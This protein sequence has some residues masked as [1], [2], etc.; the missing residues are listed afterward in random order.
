MKIEHTALYVGPNV[1]AN[2]PVIQLTVDLGPLEAWPTGRLGPA[3]QQGL[4]AALPGLRDHRCS[5]GVPGGFVRRLTEDEGT[6]LG[7]VLEHTCIELQYGAG[8]NVH[9]GRARQVEGRPG[10]Y[11]VVYEYFDAEVGDAAG[12]LAVRLLQS[13]LPPECRPPEAEPSFD[14]AEAH[15]EFVELAR[16][17]T[18]GPSTAALVRAAERRKIPWERLDG[19]HLIQF[20]YGARQHRIHAA[21][22]DHTSSIGVEIAHDKALT[23]RLLDEAGIPVPA[24]ARV[25]DAE[26]AVAVAEQFGYPVVVKPLD[27]NQGRGVRPDVRSA[28]EV[29]EAFAEARAEGSGV[30]V[31]E[32]LSGFDHRMLVVNGG[33]VAAAR[34]VP[35]HVVGDGASTVEALLAR[36]NADPRRGA[37]HDAAL[38]RI[39]LDAEAERLLARRG[40]T[41]ESVPP[42]GDIVYLRATA[43]LSRGGTAI[44]VTERVHPDNRLLAER[45]ARTVGLDIAGV[46]FITTDVSRSHLHHGGGVN[47]VN[48]APGLRMHL[49]PS[50]GSKHDVA[51]S[52]MAQ[53]FPE[54]TP[55]RI[56]IAAITGTNGKTTTAHIVT[57]IATAAEFRVGLTTTNG[58][59]IDGRQITHDDA[60]GPLSARL[61]LR[62]PTVDCA[63][64]ETARGGIAR[65]GLAFRH[66]TVGAVLNVTADHLGIDG[67]ETLEEMARVKRNVVEVATDVAVLNADDPLC[68]AMVEYTPARTV[69]LVSMTPDNEVIERHVAAGGS[70][71]VLDHGFR[72]TLVYRKGAERTAL[73]AACDIPSTHEGRVRFSI[74]N[75]MFGAAIAIGLGI[76]LDAVRAG[77]LSYE[78]SITCTPGRLNVYDGHPFRVIMD[79]GHNPVAVRAMC[80]AARGLSLGGRTICVLAA[81]GDRRDDDIREIAQ[82]AAGLADV[83]VTRRDDSLRGRGPAEIPELLRDGL[84]AAGVAAEMIRVVPEET[85]A[86]AA[87]LGMAR[88]GD[89]LLLFADDIPRTWKQIVDFRPV[90]APA[91]APAPTRPVARAPSVKVGA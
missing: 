42:V 90:F 19:D 16:R 18:L 57:A 73:V 75:A 28:D 56:P 39:E 51:D 34:R 64:L 87:A 83:Y 48:A 40:Y 82:A 80:E 20:G 78:S 35:A 44:D 15:A 29:R 72:S 36:V 59:Y 31:E 68:L 9:F 81:P 3:F 79:Y 27:G 4:L 74:Q 38:T 17:Q 66:C 5:F 70:A 21:L 77:L 61:V 33:L 25:Y 26:E 10:V 88:P 22:T 53:L 91:R 47:E 13:L 85:E 55:A 37:G 86:I 1:W 45:A 52:I 60:S 67:I 76:D 30:L 8:F 65:K 24:Q 7:H 89:L 62:D 63:V 46:D 41:R 69:C 14:F 2:F 32:H 11:H 50:T 71:V 43:N 84:V 49:S 58:V 12:I 23:N 54:G 6:W